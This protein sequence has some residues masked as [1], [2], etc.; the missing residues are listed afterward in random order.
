[1]HFQKSKTSPCSM[2]FDKVM[3]F[4]LHVR[5]LLIKHGEG[6]NPSYSQLIKYPLLLLSSSRIMPKISTWHY[7]SFGRRIRAPSKIKNAAKRSRQHAGKKYREYAQRHVCFVNEQ[8]PWP[9]SNINVR[10]CTGHLCMKMS[11]SPFVR[12][13]AMPRILY[14]SRGVPFPV[15]TPDSIFGWISV[16]LW[17]L[18][19]EV[20]KKKFR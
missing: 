9:H 6:D 1:M 8:V 19:W 18:R 4:Y 12:A 7:F 14:L 17:L 3:W 10:F 16:V 11:S 5:S 13:W 15:W 2:V 20:I